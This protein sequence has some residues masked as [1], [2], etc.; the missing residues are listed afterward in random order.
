MHQ[1]KKTKT[2]TLKKVL[3]YRTQFG[4]IILL[5]GFWILIGGTSSYYQRFVNKTIKEKGQTYLG[6]IKYKDCKKNSFAIF[7]I[8]GFIKRI[9]LKRDCKK[10]EIGDKLEF[11]G[12]KLNFVLTTE[13]ISN[14][15]I[16][17]QLISGL[18]IIL[19]G[20]LLIRIKM[21]SA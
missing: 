8:D 17:S 16:Y 21:A 13:K 1:P 9:D 10:Y 11:Y 18:L 6:T 3:K 14:W 5:L 2:R 7:D 12:Y 20:V 15:T 4:L 19:T